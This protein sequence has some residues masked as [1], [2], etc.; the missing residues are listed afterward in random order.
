MWPECKILLLLGTGCS[1]DRVMELEA[2]H[3]KAKSADSQIFEVDPGVVPNGNGNGVGTEE[4][5]VDGR[6]G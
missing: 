2:R 6:G 3:D 1:R 4:T 5:A